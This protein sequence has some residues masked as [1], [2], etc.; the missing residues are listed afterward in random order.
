MFVLFGTLFVD[1]RPHAPAW[2]VEVMKSRSLRTQMLLRSGVVISATV[3]AITS[4]VIGTT[5]AFATGTGS[6]RAWGNNAHGQ[7]GN[8]KS[9]TS[10][11]APVQVSDLH[12]V[13]AIAAGGS[14][15]LAL[16]RT[17]TV[18]AW[19]DNASGQIGN[20]ANNNEDTPVSVTGLTGVTAI[21]AG[22]T[23]SLAL[24][25]D[26]TVMAWG[27]N[28]SGE[29]G[30]GSNAS[31]SSTPVPVTGLGEVTAIS[32]GVNHALAL[33]SDGTVMAWGDNSFGELGDGTS[34]SF[35]ESPVAVTSLSGV[36]AIA[37]GN[38]FSEALVAGGDVM[39]WGNN[40]S[41]QL[42]DGS[43]S[44]S[45]VPVPV[46][47]VSSVTS[48]A[49]GGSFGLAVAGGAVSAWGDNFYGELGNGTNAN[50]DVPISVSGLSGVTS[51]AAGGGHALATLSTGVVMAWGDNFYGEIGIRTAST[52]VDE[53]VA[54]RLSRQISSV[55]ASDP[56]SNRGFSMALAGN[57]T[58]KTWG[59]DAFGQLGDGSIRVNVTRPVNVKALTGA[60]AVSAGSDFSLALTTNGTVTAWG[61]NSAGQLGI[62]TTGNNIV[63]PKAIGGLTGVTAIAAGFAHGLALLA[64]GTVMA[65]GDNSYGEL[66]DGS[67]VGSDTPVA[68][69]GLSDAIAVAAG[70]DYSLA[71]LSDGT[72]MAWGDNSYGE[73]GDGTT[74]GSDLPVPVIGLTGITAIAAGLEHGLALGS[75]GSVMA[76]GNNGAGQLGDGAS[77]GTSDTPVTVTGLTGSTVTAVAA[78]LDHSLGLLSNGTVV[79]WGDNRSGELGNATMAESA[80]PVPVSNLDNVTSISAGSSFSLALVSKT[81][82]VYSWGLDAGVQSDAPAVVARISRNRFHFGWR[83]LQPGSQGTSLD[84]V[85]CLA[86]SQG[87]TDQP[88]E[89][90]KH[91]P[92]DSIRVSR[93]Q[94][95]SSSGRAGPSR[96]SALTRQLAP[97][98]L[99]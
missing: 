85:Q 4:C 79:A 26:G 41:G 75:D 55:S 43:T 95:R 63:T 97:Q 42:G 78:G 56:G 82:D 54:V 9:V 1:V 72:V 92:A 48:I 59:Y 31:F 80:T 25:S 6:V 64:N 32:A 65:W 5:P 76:W 61:D 88:D 50:S 27:D 66:G 89:D 57:H 58:V 33:L 52:E 20:G 18:M 30:D 28:S 49:A 98:D 90:S 99:E 83:R 29:L 44:E 13:E 67:T 35:S 19:G 81:R 94:A 39:A 60:I 23:F 71:L 21:A 14:H 70:G 62:G 91:Q 74:V 68:V 47:G 34:G 7:L 36:I 2:G 24:L 40:T 51:I 10:N 84:A 22:G 93:R 17:G 11:N 53:P 86:D 46:I 96:S 87:Q 69:S 73:L 3:M 45:N 12:Q 38:G 37:A 8:G 77:G 15:G 16:L